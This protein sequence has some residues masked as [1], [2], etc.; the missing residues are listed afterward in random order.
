MHCT[1]ARWNSE[2]GK[3]GRIL[4]GVKVQVVVLERGTSSIDDGVTTTGTLANTIHKSDLIS[5]RTTKL[6]GKCK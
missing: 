4:P 1:H 5:D 3:C 2:R 6:L